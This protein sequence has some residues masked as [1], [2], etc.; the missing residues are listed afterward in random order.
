MKIVIL[1][2]ADLAAWYALKLLLPNLSEHQCSLFLSHRVG[3]SKPKPEPIEKLSVF[4]K[5]C[6]N[7]LI[8][9]GHSHPFEQYNA[10]LTQPFQFLE[11]I[12][13]PQ[14]CSELKS[15]EP[16]L[17][18]S[19]RFGLILKDEVI[20]I[21]KKGVINLH[22]GKLP[23]YQGVMATFYALLN[24]DKQLSTTLHY[25][26]DSKIDT[27]DVLATSCLSVDEHKSYL[28]HV[29]N[30]YPD[31]CKNIL[32]AVGQLTREDVQKATHQEGQSK[33][34]SY[35]DENLIDD[36]YNKGLKLF[37]TNEDLNFLTKQP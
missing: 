26:S 20:A 10:Y 32:N 27:G 13:H 12:N 25:I 18:I 35:P 17:F 1:A 33:Y 19:I 24:G 29:L 6:L 3:S 22:S 7:S 16:D 37:E 5:N 9:E 36:F 28:W 31:G 8:L 14:I 21:P 4:E 30:L 15:L 11:K 23:E 2:N 34:Y